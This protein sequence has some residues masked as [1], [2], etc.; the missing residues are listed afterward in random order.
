MIIYLNYAKLVLAHLQTEFRKVESSLRNHDAR[1]P[2]LAALVS[3]RQQQVE[4]A[5][6]DKA[7]F[8]IDADVGESTIP[9]SFAT[10]QIPACVF[11]VP[12]C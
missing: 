7:K 6:K 11:N 8:C 10:T 4:I 12:K 1:D 9:Q 5:T 2:Y 3:V